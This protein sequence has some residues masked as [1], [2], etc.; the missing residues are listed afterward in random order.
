MRADLHGLS[1]DVPGSRERNDINSVRK[2]IVRLILEGLRI[3]KNKRKVSMSWVD[4]QAAVREALGVELAGWPIDIPMMRPGRLVLESARR[5]RDMLRTGAIH[6]V[7]L[8][9]AQHV[10]L[11]KKHNRKR[12]ASAT[13]QLKTRAPR[14][15]LGRKRGPRAKGKKATAAGSDDEDENEDADADEDEDEDDEEEE[16]D[17]EEEEHSTSS[18]RRIF[19][20]PINTGASTSSATASTSTTHTPTLP[21]TTHTP[22]F[23]AATMGMDIDSGF[24]VPGAAAMDIN[25]ANRL[26]IG[27]GLDEFGLPLAGW[28]A[29]GISGMGFGDD[30]DFDFDFGQLDMSRL[31]LEPNGGTGEEF[32]TAD[33]LAGTVFARDPPA[34]MPFAFTQP[35]PASAPSSSTSV[36]A[37][38]TNTLAAAGTHMGGTKRVRLASDGNNED[39]DMPPLKKSRKPRSDKGKKKQR[40][41]NDDAPAEKKV[42]KQRSDKGKKRPKP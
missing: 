38:T 19:T 7:P 15:D 14:S 37:I 32:P 16:D 17:D 20:T 2:E 36:F 31:S 30:F 11:I 22:A 18:S 4:Y 12:A 1:P 39:A 33:A 13:G 29:G 8:S 26:A 35:M 28:G 9:K 21:S 10:E 3:I 5:I 25:G 24:A 27:E 6:W 34:P 40:G 41:E 42:R 23:V